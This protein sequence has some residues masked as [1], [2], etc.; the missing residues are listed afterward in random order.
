[1]HFP[2][3]LFAYKRKYHLSNTIKALLNCYLAGQS[4]VFI[5]L[6]G[7]KNNAS[8]EEINAI[9]EVSNY[10]HSISGFKS[11]NIIEQAENLGLIN[12]V[13]YGITTV[14]K[15]STA[16]IVIEDDI[17]VSKDFLQFMNLSL[18][19]YEEEERVAGVS[20]YSFPIHE[21]Q[22]YFCRTGSCWGWGT[23]Q[24]VWN[25]FLLKR[26]QLTL[27]NLNGN[28]RQRFNVYN[29]FYENMF[30]QNKQGLL[31]SWAI[32]FYLY[33]FTKKQFFLFPGPNL[34]D[35]SGFDG[36]GSHAVNSNFFTNNNP[37]KSIENFVFPD[38]IK[39]NKNI[40]KKITKLF[41]EGLSKPTRFKRYWKKMVS[42]ISHQ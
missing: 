18:K 17:I 5:F 19:K 42:L 16:V 20:G 1:L 4:D 13:I 10:V 40:T 12:A 32:D 26:D 39:E 11:I 25:D 27:E 23:Y 8:V 36:S 34:V 35:N 38:A 3:A 6:D 14:L 28:E 24:R 37:V 29:N 31:Q 41:Y 21:K 33:Y 15:N 2:I 7:P 22:P 9:K 30:Q